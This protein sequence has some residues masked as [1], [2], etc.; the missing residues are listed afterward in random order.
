MEGEACVGE[1]REQH[2]ERELSNDEVLTSKII[3]NMH[4]H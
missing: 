1:P 4:L 3:L 2:R